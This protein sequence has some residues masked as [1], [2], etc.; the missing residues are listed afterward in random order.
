MIIS[1]HMATLKHTWWCFRKGERK[2]SVDF[3]QRWNTNSQSQIVNT[4]HFKNTN[5]F[6]H[7]VI[8]LIENNF[9]I[10]KESSARFVFL[11]VGSRSRYTLLTLIEAGHRK[12]AIGPRKIYIG[13]LEFSFYQYF[14]TELLFYCDLTFI[15][16][17]RTN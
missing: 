8:N 17:R 13:S 7:K 3:Y 12:S 11:R 2:S 15:C 10:K 14:Q 9:S 5:F 1:G 6:N 4:E 16:R